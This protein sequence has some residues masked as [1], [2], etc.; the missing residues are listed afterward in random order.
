MA[1]IFGGGGGGSSGGGRLEESGASSIE[2]GPPDDRLG[3]DGRPDP[4]PPDGPEDGP[5]RRTSITRVSLVTW[6]SLESAGL[7]HSNQIAFIDIIIRSYVRNVDIPDSFFQ[8]PGCWV[9][10]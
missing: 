3:L 1:T 10:L 8:N 2:T 5:S 4:D 7:Q 6:R 9:I